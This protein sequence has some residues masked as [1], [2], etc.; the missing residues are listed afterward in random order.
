MGKDTHHQVWWMVPSPW[1]PQ[2]RRRNQFLPVVLCAMACMGVHGRVK[3]K[4]SAATDLVCVVVWCTCSQS[5]SR[6]KIVLDSIGFVRVQ[7][8]ILEKCHTARRKDQQRWQVLC[9][10]SRCLT[11]KLLCSL[12]TCSIISSSMEDYFSPIFLFCK[13]FSHFCLLFLFDPVG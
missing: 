5:N 2:G 13:V 7:V 3:V 6:C 11:Q 9:E 8:V 4:R 1:T 12:D 10:T